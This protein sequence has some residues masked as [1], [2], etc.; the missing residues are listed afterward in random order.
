MTERISSLDDGYQTGDL[1]IFPEAL[2]DKTLLYVASNNSK[3]RLVQTLTYNNSKVIVVEDTTGFPDSGIIRVGPDIGKPGDHEL[4]GYTKKTANTFQNLQ[5]GFGGSKQNF[6]RPQGVYV[7]NSVNADYHNA[8]KDAIINIEHDLGVSVDPD[9]ES[10]N[11]ILKSQETRFLA[12]K[13]L[14]RAFPPKGPPPHQVR[15][16]NFTTGHVIRYFWDFGDGG[17]SLEKSPIHTYLTEGSYT[18][19]LNVITSTGAQ[20]IATKRDYITVDKDESIPFFYVESISQPYSVKTASE[21]SAG[22]NPTQPKEFV[23]ID[24]TDGDIVQRN[25][26]FGDGVQFTQNDPNNHV[27]SHIYAKPGEYIVTV[28]IIFSN[29]RLKKVELPEP[30][31]VL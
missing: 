7:S 12:P 14:F 25:W 1:S 5:R 30:L 19:K 11:G 24:Q 22:G 16:Q 6:W 15:F 26:I 21:L 31:V 9:P 20:G 2:D 27:S 13:P 8:V 23:F 4:I 10:L 29:S 3:T 28:L 18:V 17:T